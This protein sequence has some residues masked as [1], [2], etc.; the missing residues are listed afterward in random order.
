MSGHIQD[1]WYAPGR[2]GG[3]PRRTVK[4]GKGRRWKARYLDP[5]GR[6]R[7]KSFTRKADGEEF[8]AIKARA[9]VRA[10][11]QLAHDNTGIDPAGYYVYLLWETPDD[12]KPLYVGCSGNI[13][14]RIGSHLHYV[15]KRSRIGW[16]TLIRC[17]S[18]QAMLRRETELIRKY[19]PEW[20]KRVP[21]L[22]S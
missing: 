1:L 21:E 8:L 20:N 18:E 17:T 9:R 13:L 4:H 14:S 5:D 2:R 11:L 6:E 12:G 3:K 22:V 19:R 7:S 15:G 16:V 10:E